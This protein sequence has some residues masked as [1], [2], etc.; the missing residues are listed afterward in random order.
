MLDRCDATL[1]LD[2][3]RGPATC[4]Y[5]QL[6]VRLAV[7]FATITSQHFGEAVGIDDALYSYVWPCCSLQSYAAASLL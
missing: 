3:C 5:G 4:P 7:G 1:S 6:L 2:P